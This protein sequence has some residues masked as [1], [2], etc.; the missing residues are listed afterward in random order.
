MSQ[1]PTIN[2]PVHIV[3]ED[4]L[5]EIYGPGDPVDFVAVGHLASAE[6]IPALV[7]INKL[8]SRHSAVVG[9]TG[10]G[11]STTVAGLLAALSDP[12]DYPSAR[13]VV[14]DI[15]GEYAKALGDRSTVFRIS[16][17]TV[18]G[19]KPLHIPFWA[20]SFEELMGVSFGGLEEKPLAAVA[21]AVLALKREAITK[22]PREGADLQRLTWTRQFRSAFIS[23]GLTFINASIERSFQ[24]PALPPAK[25]NQHTY[26]ARMANESLAMRCLWFLRNIEL[27]KQLVPRKNVSSGDP[28]QLACVNNWL[29]WH[30]NSETRSLPSF[31]IPAT[32]RQRSMG[33]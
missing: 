7:N 28:T 23:F 15:H 22:Q 25:S 30:P 19:E 12:Q 31:S 27:S 11:K 8:L 33:R 10:A 9:T 5:R 16:P 20:L 26:K 24:N 29:C 14:F 1:H 2:D 18:K 4:D 3:T 6:S 32:G 21:D 17:D 13:I